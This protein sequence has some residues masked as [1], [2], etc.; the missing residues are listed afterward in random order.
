MKD[1]IKRMKKDQ[2]KIIGGK[3]LVHLLHRR[4]P[5]RHLREESFF[6]DFVQKAQVDELLR[7]GDLRIGR[8]R[9]EHVEHELYPLGRRAGARST[10]KSPRLWREPDALLRGNIYQ[11][12]GTVAVQ[13]LNRMFQRT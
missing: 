1:E 3:R 9:G 4:I 12:K 10:I 11:R 8:L 6:L 5:P 2:G 7:L 13:H